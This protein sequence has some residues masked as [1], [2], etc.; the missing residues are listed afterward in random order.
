MLF[1]IKGQHDPK[2]GEEAVIGL[3][4]LLN[5]EAF[6]RRIPLPKGT[7]IDLTLDTSLNFDEVLDGVRQSFETFRSLRASARSDAVQPKA[8]K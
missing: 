7:P 2:V 4:E 5:G 6:K 1:A 8:P 3:R